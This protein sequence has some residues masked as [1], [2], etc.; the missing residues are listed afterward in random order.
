LGF[1]LVKGRCK[2]LTE[3]DLPRGCPPGTRPT[4]ETDNCAPV[5]ALKPAKVKCGK[6]TTKVEGRCVPKQ[7]P[8]T[9]CGP[10]FHLEGHKRVHGFREPP[11]QKKMPSLQ[12][13]AIKKGCPKG[14]AGTRKRAA[15]TTTE[16]WDESPAGSSAGVFHSQLKR[17]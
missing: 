16:R 9:V 2:R 3:R 6:G 8:A 4:P 10:G 17:T 12:I 15:T 11:P 13:E 5:A 14:M 1:R 7:D